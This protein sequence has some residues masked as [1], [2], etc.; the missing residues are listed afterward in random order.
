MLS[1]QLRKV[2]VQIKISVFTSQHYKEIAEI[3]K[4]LPLGKDKKRE[5]ATK[6][7]VMFRKDN[8]NYDEDRFFQ[9]CGLG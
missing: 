8:K 6:F 2:A 9:A 1:N 4:E 7:S 3:I 5:V